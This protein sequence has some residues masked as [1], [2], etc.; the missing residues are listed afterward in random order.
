[1]EWPALPSELTLF[2]QTYAVSIIADLAA[3]TG[4]YGETHFDRNSISIDGACARSVQWA[5]LGHEVLH[6]TDEALALGLDEEEISR[7]DTGLFEFI[8]QLGIGGCTCK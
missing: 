6:I 3:A 2:G 5:T 4:H 8:G 1:M 7:L